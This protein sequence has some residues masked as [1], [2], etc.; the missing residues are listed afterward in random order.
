[1]KEQIISYLK[2]SMIF[3]IKKLYYWLTNDAEIL[4]FILAVLHILVSVS[5]LLCSFL[6][7]TVYPIWQFKLGTYFFMVL[8]W[9]QHIFLNVC[10]FTVAELSLS[11]IP[12]SNQYLAYFYSFFLGTNISEALTRL[13]MAETIAIVCFGLELISLFCQYLYSLYNIQL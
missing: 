12:P 2:D 9:L 11:L 10:I 3:G 6:A 5:L 13:V 8:V 7:H 1:M 4:G